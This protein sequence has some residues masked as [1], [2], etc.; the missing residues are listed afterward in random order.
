MKTFP[1]ISILLLVAFLLSSTLVY[2]QSS[3]EIIRGKVTSSGDNEPLISVTILEVDPSNRIISG[4][5]SNYDGE[6]VLQ[7]KSTQNKLQFKYI[8]FKTNEIPIGTKRVINVALDEEAL[9]LAEA[10]VVGQAVVNDGRFAIPEREISTALQKIST[11]EFEG[12]QVSSIDDALQGRISGLDIVNVSGEPGAGMSMRIRGTTTISASAEPLVVVN[13]VPLTY[14][15]INDDFDFATANEDQYAQLIDVNPDDIESIVILKDAA[16][17]AIW[18]SQGANGVLQ[19]TT[20]KGKRGPTRVSYSY[21]LSGSRQPKGIN[22]LNGDDYTMLMKQSYYNPT[23]ENLSAGIPELNY[24]T[25]FTEYEN[26]NN[27]TDWIDAVSQYG[28]T[29]DNNLTISGGGDKITFR[30]S[31][32]YYNQTGTVIGQLLERFS[33]RSSIDYRVSDRILFTS[34][35]SYTYSNNDKNYDNLLGIAYKKMPNVSIYEQDLYGNDTDVYYNI[36]TDSQL[37]KSQKELSNPVAVAMLAQNNTKS[38]RISPN[39][40]LRYDLLDPYKYK[41]TLRLN[42][43]VSFS[44]GNSQKTTFLPSEISNANWDNKNVNLA[45]NSEDESLSLQFST[46]AN[47]RPAFENRDHSLMLQ[48]SFRVNTGTSGS[49]GISAYGLPSTAIRDATVPAVLG[50]TSSST[51]ESRALTYSWSGHYAYKGRYIFD[52]TAAFNGSSRFGDNF[53]F[54]LF[55]GISAKWI[56]SDEPF[57]DDLR[58]IV[59]MFSFRPSWGIAGNQPSTEYLHLSRYKSYDKGYIDMIAVYPI[60]IR[61]TDLRWEKTN[62]INLGTDLEFMNGK[63]ALD[64]NYYMKHTTDLLFDKIGLP[65]HTGYEELSARNGGT[66]NNSGW[67]ANF[68]VRELIKIGKFSMSFNFNTANNRNI[69]VELDDDILATMNPDYTY[70]NGEYLT[71]IQEKNPYGSIYGFRYKG[72]YQYNEYIKDVQESAPVVR[73]EFDNVIL[74]ANGNTKPMYYAYG[75]TAQYEFKGGDA[76]YEDINHDGSI[77]E[78]DIV[79]LGNSLPKFMGGFGTNLRW[80]QLSLNLFFN[81]RTGNKVVNDARMKAENMYTND[82]QSIAVNWRWRKEGDITEMPRALYNY[83]YNWL[84]SDRYVEDASFLRFKYMTFNYAV[85]TQYLKPYKLNTLSFYL[86][87]QNLLVFTNYTGVDPEVGYGSRSVAKDSSKT[88]RSKDFTLGI[89]IGF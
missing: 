57:W 63:Y 67:E 20:K 28:F 45:S 73:D 84:G 56:V 55:P 4:T 2:A 72:V 15:E 66:M 64:L 80:K 69:I 39:F 27:N 24:D 89:K 31:A 41:S 36:R 33:T 22:M 25:N 59:N 19:I 75:T 37:N 71:R 51:S 13:D 30:V 17:T 11:E 74:D 34:D 61:L 16:S 62:S 82:N 46:S 76:I 79:Y 5:V 3:S 86:T 52:F 78:L 29:H 38:Y 77:D 23:L 8:G 7:V 88:P 87:F 18:G 54:G 47:Y 1:K 12:I 50:S 6:Y 48:A 9:D 32:G 35:F 21:R 58:Y 44:L 40:S 26:Y 70:A 49:L 68:H 60:N 81:F 14:I 85:P 53:K 83:G 10:V 43:T 65:G 42:S